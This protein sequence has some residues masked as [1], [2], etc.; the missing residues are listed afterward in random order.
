MTN[1]RIIV[2]GAFNSPWSYLAS[3][4]A[5]LLE[6]V[7]LR[8]DW[9]A[10]DADTGRPDTPSDRARGFQSVRQDMDQIAATI[11]PGE[12]LPYTLAGFITNTSAAVSIYGDAYRL[13]AGPAIRSLLF[14]AFWLHGI[15]LN[16]EQSVHTLV[17]DSLQSELF[18][19]EASPGRANP[20][21]HLSHQW[22]TEWRDLGNPALPVL[23]G[24]GAT[25]RCG[26]EAVEWFGDELV[27]R[28]VD[29]ETARH[30][31]LHIGQL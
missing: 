6:S 28:G 25:G 1:G 12:R 16:N 30:S 8:I 3:R 7:G 21:P 27:N 9:R 5:E 19:G 13:G 10:I 18:A 24:G 31:L 26:A 20:A 4:R 11:L 2:Y 17:T 14:E 22:A 15:D 23:I 29:I